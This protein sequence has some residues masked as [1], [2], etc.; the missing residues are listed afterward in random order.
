MSDCEKYIE[1]ISSMVDGEL[2]NEQET[3]L[4]THMENCDECKRVYNAFVGISGAISENMVEPPEM[5]AES[6]MHKI[7]QKNKGAFNGRFVFGRFTA[8]AACFVLIM[9]GA[10]HFGFFDGASKSTAMSAAEPKAAET[11]N[12]AL[13][14][15]VGKA[16]TYAAASPETTNP[17]ATNPEA[18]NDGSALAKGKLATTS[19]TDSETASGGTGENTTQPDIQQPALTGGPS[20]AGESDNETL[21]YGFPS[22]KM[23]MMYRE[24]NTD[25]NKEPS[26]I[27]KATELTLFGG[28]YNSEEKDKN[29]Q[30][31]IVNDKANLSALTELLTAVSD[32][33]IDYSNVDS[34]FIENDPSYSILV[35]ANKA[36]NESATDKI[37]CVWFVKGE[38]W[39]ELE[40]AA[41][42]GSNTHAVKILYKAVG[43]QE[44][45]DNLVK[46]LEN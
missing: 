20:D 35:P 39:C 2:T 1:L 23:A 40:D 9:F 16:D 44:K 13:S 45:F 22:P 17:Q 10:A 27:F 3:E 7:G 34:K 15:S 46:Q 5:L 37:V 28:K 8:I 26:C 32:D 11:Q 43:L 12:S 30:L 4:R 36:V 29:N 24:N 38:T 41:A 19:G 14:D 18:T 6:V 42:D 25:S 31:V 21:Q 33:T